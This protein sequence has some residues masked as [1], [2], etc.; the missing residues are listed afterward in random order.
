MLL[1]REEVNPH[2]PD[3]TGRRPLAHAAQ[4]GHKKVVKI[5]LAYEEVD[6]DEK[7]TWGALLLWH[8]A[9]SGDYC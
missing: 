1:G 8:A 9:T 7:G 5:L 2:M 4:R 3:D 6:P